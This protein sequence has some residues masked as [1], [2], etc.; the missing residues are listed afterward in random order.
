M[1]IIK[2]KISKNIFNYQRIIFSKFSAKQK[3]NLKEKDKDKDKNNKSVDNN[4]KYEDEK[5]GT[6]PQNLKNFYKVRDYSNNKE[7]HNITIHESINSNNKESLKK[8]INKLLNEDGIIPKESEEFKKE[9]RSANYGLRFK[10]LEKI[11][12]EK[13]VNNIIEEYDLGEMTI[14]EKTYKPYSFMVKYHDEQRKY[15]NP[16]YEELDKLDSIPIKGYNKLD[17][18]KSSGKWYPHKNIESPNIAEENS[19]K[20]QNRLN[21]NYNYNYEDHTIFTREYKKA[22][23]IDDSIIENE[24]KLLTYI[25]NNPYSKQA[26]KFKYTNFVPLER[27]LP[28]DIHKYD[29]WVPEKTKEE[30]KVRI[31]KYSKDITEYD[32]WRTFT[33]TLPYIKNYSDNAR[34]IKISPVKLIK[35]FGQPGNPIESD[36]TGTYF[37]QDSNLDVFVL[38]DWQQT[39]KTWGVNLSDE[40]YL[41]QEE[42]TLPLHRKIKFPTPDE[43][44]KLEEPQLFKFNFSKIAERRKFYYWLINELQGEVVDINEELDKIFGKINLYENYD[45]EFKSSERKPAIYEFSQEYVTGKKNPFISFP[46]IYPPKAI[47]LNNPDSDLF[48]NK[49][50]LKQKALKGLERTIDENNI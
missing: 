14:A 16:I 36:M 22:K 27:K 5:T 32:A 2:N 4:K 47:S 35:R 44:W 42:N 10:N 20:K 28:I 29:D 11:S 3:P 49:F 41:K 38:F 7:V 34:K 50:Y 13:F 43:F 26:I 25:K 40:L 24:N 9:V 37:F 18:F 33:E 46:D 23:E 39:T 31:D 30:R 45:K 12:D 15:L 6:K 1:N 48:D 19:G 21:I 8:L 17:E